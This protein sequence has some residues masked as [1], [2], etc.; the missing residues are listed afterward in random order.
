MIVSL[1]APKVEEHKLG[2]KA[3]NLVHMKRAGFEVPNGI[4]LTTDVYSEY[5][6]HNNLT[7]QI[8]QILSS[9]L[10]LE[11]KSI[12]IQNMFSL[13]RLPGKM[14]SEIEE[15]LKKLNMDR[16]AVRSSSTL[17]D[18]SEMSFAGQY[19]TYLGVKK[20][21]ILKALVDC[22]KSLWNVRAMSYRKKNK[23]SALPLHAVLVQEMVDAQSAGVIFT[24]NPLN[25][26]RSEYVVNASYGIG[27]AIVSGSVMPDEY[28]FDVVKDELIDQTIH[29]KNEKIIL[30]KE[31]IE[32]VGV[33]DQDRQQNVL[34]FEEVKSLVSVASKIQSLFKAPQD[35]EFAIDRK[36]I[37]HI[38]QSRNITTLFPIDAF[39]QDD[40]LRPHLCA[41]SVLLGMK[42]AFTPLGADIYGGMFPKVLQVMTK[43]KKPIPSTFVKYAGARIYLDITYL[44]ASRFVSKQFAG[45]FSGSD[46]PLKATMETMTDKH[47]YTLRHQ[48]VRFKIPWGIMRYSLS[49]LGPFREAS[50][51]EPD[52]KYEAIRKLGDQVILELRE[53]AKTLQTLEEKVAFCDEIMMR[54]FLLSQKQAMYCTEVSTLPRIKKMVEKLFGDRYNLDVLTYSLPGCI[55]VELSRALNQLAKYYSE[56]N[57][58]P[59]KNEVRFEQL[60][61]K[62]GHRGTIE[63]DAGTSRWSEDPTY[64]L[65]Q[66]KSYMRDKTYDSNLQAI[67]NGAIE[68]NALID[69]IAMEV[70]KVKSVKHG[71]RL[72]KM[73]LTYR[74]AAGMREYPKF[75]ILQGLEIARKV[76]L[77]LGGTL[78]ASGILKE[79]EDIFYLRR[80][81]LLDEVQVLLSNAPY[82]SEFEKLKSSL[83]NQVEVNKG[84][85]TL[86][87]KRISIPRIVM[88]TGE[89]FFTGVRKDLQEGMI[90][91]YPLSS[92]IYEGN[93][94]I[95]QDP[96]K[97]NLNPGE[98]LVAESTNPAW[99]PLFMNAKALIVEY[100]GPLSHG[101][102][103]AREYGIPAVVGISI[104][105]TKFK[106]GQRV[107]V[108]GTRGIV[109]ILD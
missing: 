57:I 84:L 67:E 59:S 76:M 93:I 107:R 78:C 98:I 96:L 9:D 86:E 55:T 35:I 1:N 63:L 58:E 53:E 62:F 52:R 25:G 11:A 34:S 77:E 90:Q 105:A 70:G 64:L 87:M 79:K 17:E 88:N 39:D 100:G 32:T 3:L 12:Q 95:V 65:N 73:M 40:K 31:G 50:Q 104:K 71:N 46:M 48:G 29:K 15:H 82:S 101:G 89:L 47:G 74:R 72:K 97:A 14:V 2:G 54:V 33:Q 69:E 80:A 109:E 108:D 85:Y 24:A 16:L 66:V 21:D 13:D 37:I 26:I 44:M 4:V 94:R 22:W 18:L 51:V 99:T 75:N 41:S 8:E 23:V 92:G 60:L 20:Q 6:I 5:L 36:G 49:M 45:A 83:W 61:I 27:E 19:V 43:S 28:V 30:G 42:E 102:I 38:L 7:E 103:V 10:E 68:A 81:T 106:D 91:G 56:Q